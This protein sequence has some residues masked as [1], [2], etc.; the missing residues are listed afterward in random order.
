MELE[1]T[2]A[3]ILSLLIVGGGQS[4]KI[5]LV[6]FEN[7]ITRINVLTQTPYASYSPS[8]KIY[9]Q[10]DKVTG[11]DSDAGT[12]LSLYDVQGKRLIHRVQFQELPS[13][14]PVFS[15]GDFVYWARR[16]NEI[17]QYSISKSSIVNKFGYEKGEVVHLELNPDDSLSS[18]ST[19]EDDKFT[20]HTTRYGASGEK[21]GAILSERWLDFDLRTG[22]APDLEVKKLQPREL[23]YI[24][25]CGGTADQVRRVDRAHRL[26][27]LGESV[28]DLRYLPSM[29]VTE[30][31]GPD[32]MSGDGAEAF[33]Y[34]NAIF[35]RPAPTPTGQSKQIELTGHTSAPRLVGYVA[36]YVMATLCESYL[37]LWSTTSGA[38]LARLDLRTPNDSGIS[39]GAG[40]EEGTVTSVDFVNNDE[41]LVST[42]PRFVGGKMMAPV[43]RWNFRKGESRRE[44]SSREAFLA[45]WERESA[46][47]PR[48]EW[49]YP[50]ILAL[51]YPDLAETEQTSF[52]AQNRP[53]FGSLPWATFAFQGRT[54]GS[55]G[56]KGKR[57]EWDLEN[58][59][60]IFEGDN[61]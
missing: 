30:G 51:T 35:L 49:T 31:P 44:S 12:Y 26:V 55:R 48:K 37:H 3:L 36:P 42:S 56:A 18:S 32:A 29:S 52:F 28:V 5:P 2:S 9:G 34:P 27:R 25:M 1:V 40:F 11:F 8:G 17:V 39:F 16:N 46:S 58:M 22:R 38:R 19:T 50:T 45:A 7:P 20:V 10:V 4:L 61:K 60:E 53:L 41:L 43:V 15:D 54:I 13:A 57:V 23:E 14:G 24:L 47:K 6:K 21:L 59:K 33:A